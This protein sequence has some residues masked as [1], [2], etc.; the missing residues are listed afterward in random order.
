MK[1]ILFVQIEIGFN[2]VG[3]NLELMNKMQK[4]Q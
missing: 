1:L 4:S 3:Q 2:A